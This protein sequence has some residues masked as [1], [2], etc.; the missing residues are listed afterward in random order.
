VTL[1]LDDRWRRSAVRRP[2][3]WRSCSTGSRIG[4]HLV[5]LSRR[6]PALEI[7]RRRARGEVAEILDGE[8]A[9]TTDE[10]AHYLNHVWSL[11][12]PDE[13]V[14]ELV[15]LTDGWPVAL[16]LVASHLAEA[17]RPGEG[18]LPGRDRRRAGDRRPGP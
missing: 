14:Q 4:L 9:F 15:A 8:L 7:E 12:L 1:V 11:A 16:H 10:A 5:L 13:T 6:R 18:T 3:S 2:A 17:R